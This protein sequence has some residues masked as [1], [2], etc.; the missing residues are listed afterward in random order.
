MSLAAIVD[1]VPQC[2]IA[3]QWRVAYG[4]ERG[5]IHFTKKKINHYYS[6]IACRFALQWAQLFAA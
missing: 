6:F 1:A 5:Q 3:L 4:S 2:R